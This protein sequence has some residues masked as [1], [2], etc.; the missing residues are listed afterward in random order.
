MKPLGLSCLK[1]MIAVLCVTDVKYFF[2]ANIAGIV[3]P[4]IRFYVLMLASVFHTA[5][6]FSCVVVS[7][8]G[9]GFHFFVSG[10]LMSVCQVGL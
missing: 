5:A 10:S 6:I 4:M 3:I 9:L 1:D 8:S 2:S 7:G